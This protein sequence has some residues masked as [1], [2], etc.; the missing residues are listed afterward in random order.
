MKLA[1]LAAAV[2]S[3]SA[4][5]FCGFYVAGGGAEL[6]NNAT[7]VVL[8]RDGTRTVLSMQ[9]NY[10]GPP[11]D[12]A[13]V[14]PVP[15]ILQKANV[16]TLPREVFTRVDTLDAPRL[17][18]YWEQDPCMPDYA[19]E[20]SGA[21]C[22]N[23]KMSAP[24]E[25]AP[26]KKK[27]KVE[28]QFEVGEYEIVVLSASDALALEQWLEENKYKIPSGA[29]PL[30][31]PY[32]QQG[33]KFFVARVNAKKVT[34]KDGMAQLSPLR[35]HYDSEKF[36]L[37]VRLGLIN[38]RD[39]Q[40]L[41]I[42][43]LAKNQR[44]EVANFPNVTVPTNIDLVPSAKSEFGPFYVSLFDRTL[45][46]NP[47]AVVTEYAWQ[48]TSCDPCPTAPL[49]EQD[50]MTLGADVL[51][52]PNVKEGFDPSQNMV[53]TRLH[54]RYDKKSLGEDLVFKAAPPIEGGREF[55]R[56]K[57]G[58]RQTAQPAS[59]NNF[60]GRYAIR[61]PW[62]GAVACANPNWGVW[63][64]NPEGGGENTTAARDAAFQKRDP[65]LLAALAEADVPVFDVKGR[66]R[67]S[68]V[69]LRAE[70]TPPVKT[71]APKQ[72]E[73]EAQPRRWWEFWK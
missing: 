38:A 39:K 13:M 33:M 52:K 60:Q 28:A 2:V 31:R 73:P 48:A 59:F 14:I 53:L 42:H 32:I 56:E 61:Y 26:M 70:E 22:M 45:K 65:A 1:A 23:C 5:A 37:P 15:V 24:T 69:A 18:E 46:A 44:Y 10:Q 55:D 6:F 68:G 57:E 64:G 54:A 12:F 16:K 43:V 34:F 30:F 51:P 35:F 71:E 25:D 20:E 62:K 49:T 7:Q 36:E 9:N 67:L 63:G 40:D 58:L 3:S 17:V 4:Y 72:Q 29:E 50:M 19:E 41:I 11:E 47:N 21:G 8:M 27:V 66:K